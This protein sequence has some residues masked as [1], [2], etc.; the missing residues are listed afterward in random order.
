M[1]VCE[2]TVEAGLSGE[3]KLDDVG[4][5]FSGE[6]E[7]EKL[8]GDKVPNVPLP[9]GFVGLEERVEVLTGGDAERG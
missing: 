9:I 3:E 2:R 1:G 8:D 4:A 6:A 5:G 7:L